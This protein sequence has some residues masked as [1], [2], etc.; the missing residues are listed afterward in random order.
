[1]GSKQPIS[2]NDSLRK[3]DPS[4]KG[5][6][7]VGSEVSE[8]QL[9]GSALK[10]GSKK[11]WNALFSPSS[12]SRQGGRSRSEPLTLERPLSDCD[13][14]PNEDAFEAGTQLDRSFSASPIT[15]CHSSGFRKRCFGEGTSSTRGDVEH[16]QRSHFKAPFLSKGKEK[17]HKLSKSE[18]I[19]G[20]KGFAGFAHHGSSVTVFPS[21]P[22]T[23][24]KGLNSAGSCGMMVVENFEVSSY[25]HS[26]SSLSFLSPSSGLA[27]PHLSLSVPVLP[28]SDIQ[29]RYP[30]KPRVISEIF[31]KKMTMGFYVMSLLAILTEM[32]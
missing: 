20:F 22:I 16:K 6:R 25:P 21:N 24:A 7:K 17:L 30:S 23:R 13:A 26:R 14:L 12:G 4:A 1:M 5:K 15:F 28:N 10:C 2:T 31:S 29:S 3:D 27:F 8:A 32:L 18:D 19:A 9:K 11:L